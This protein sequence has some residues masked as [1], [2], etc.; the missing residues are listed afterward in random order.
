MTAGGSKMEKKGL[1]RGIVK[2]EEKKEKN[3]L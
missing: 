1:M 3:L 2:D